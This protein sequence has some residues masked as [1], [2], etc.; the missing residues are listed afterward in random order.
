MCNFYSL[1]VAFRPTKVNNYLIEIL[2]AELT[3]RYIYR[4]D[5]FTLNLISVSGE[6][7]TVNCYIIHKT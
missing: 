1:K 4:A 5:Y 6:K 2:F 7:V 3:E